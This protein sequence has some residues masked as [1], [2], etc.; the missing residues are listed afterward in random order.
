MLVWIMSL[1]CI[2]FEKK[3]QTPNIVDYLQKGKIHLVINISYAESY[4][5]VL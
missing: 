4:G 2:R 5:E 1:F 3:D